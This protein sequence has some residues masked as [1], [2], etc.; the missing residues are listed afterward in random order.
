M[1]W[2]TARRA[3][4][5]AL[6]ALAACGGASAP[7]GV[8]IHPAAPP[9]LAVA[10]ATSAPA[11]ATPAPGPQRRVPRDG[12]LGRGDGVYAPVRLPLA[13][14]L[15]VGGRDGLP[16]GRDDRWRE[17]PLIPDGVPVRQRLG[18]RGYERKSD[19]WSPCVREF[20][21]DQPDGVREAL[22]EALSRYSTTCSKTRVEFQLPRTGRLVTLHSNLGLVGALERRTCELTLRAAYHG[23]PLDAEVITLIADGVR[24]S[25]TRLELE[26]ADG[27]EIA[28][29]PLTRTLARVVRRALD[30][31]DTVL[32][33][34]GPRGYEDVIITDEMKQDLQVMLD[35]LDAI[36]RP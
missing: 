2:P 27:W 8:V 25:S 35:A 7:N 21:Q 1:P 28:M 31:R 3:T 24:W 30:A 36:N 15:P 29:L 22:G 12:L 13:G 10:E 32:R 18:D 14:G 9:R 16:L 26:R 6:A 23:E 19:F 5:L 4:G 11:R 17:D 20:V 33:F 34:E